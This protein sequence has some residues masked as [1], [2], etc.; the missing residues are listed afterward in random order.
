MVITM[1]KICSEHQEKSTR[2]TEYILAQVKQ[3]KVTL[4][5][6]HFREAFQ[7]GHELTKPRKTHVLSKKKAWKNRKRFWRF[8]HKLI[9]KKN[10]QQR[11]H[12]KTSPMLE[13]DSPPDLPNDDTSGRLIQR[14]K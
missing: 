9:C 11:C 12:Q 10:T 14:T 8:L 2:A 4:Q 7:I 3:V 6:H 1:K 13:V 5:R